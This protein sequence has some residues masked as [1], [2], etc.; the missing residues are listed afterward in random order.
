MSIWD[1]Q[2]LLVWLVVMLCVLPF[3]S[4]AVVRTPYAV[5]ATVCYAVFCAVL[6]AA[7]ILVYM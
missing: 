4:W 2:P 6:A 1:F 3:W 5:E 7:L